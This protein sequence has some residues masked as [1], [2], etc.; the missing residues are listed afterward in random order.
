MFH[1]FRDVAGAQLSCLAPIGLLKIKQSISK[2][3]CGV[4]NKVLSRESNYIIDV[5]M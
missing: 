4:T 3:G 1:Y 5:V 2:K